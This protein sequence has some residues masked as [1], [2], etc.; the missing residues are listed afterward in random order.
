MT[1]LLSIFA[2][3][4]KNLIFDFGKVLVDYD[5]LQ[6]LN[7][8]FDSKNEREEFSRCI[9]TDRWLQVLEVENQPFEK[10]I[11]D[12]KSAYP[13]FTRQINV[14]SERYCDFVTGE[15]PG[16]R[17][18]LAELKERGYKL[19]GLSNWCSKV[20]VTLG[21]YPEIFSLLDGR[22]ISCEEHV[23]KPKA[24]IYN[25]L[26]ERFGLNAGE[27]LFTDDRLVNIDG[28]RAVGMDGV[29]FHDAAQFRQE[30]AM[31]SIL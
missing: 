29:V 7:P 31:R 30:L 12:M 8:Y 25:I 10:T 18:L 4:I 6:L 20:Y 19:Y 2:A 11:S 22:I 23:M 24:E 5:Y 9:L 16:M 17:Q 3:M 28:A 1:P 27:C 15:V 21:Q 14:Y 26:L 13:Q